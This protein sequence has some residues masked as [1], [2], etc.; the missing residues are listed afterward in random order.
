MIRRPPRST[1]FPYTTLFRSCHDA[2]PSGVNHAPTASAGGPYSGVEGGSV[3][4]DGSGSSDPDGGPLAYAWSFGDGIT[5]VGATPSHTKAHN[6]TY[7]LTVTGH[8]TRGP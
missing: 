2:P 7:T 1:L 5:G 3:S 6:G 4:F 8:H